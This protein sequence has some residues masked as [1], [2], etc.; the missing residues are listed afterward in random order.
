[1]AWPTVIIKIL[2]LMNGPIAGVEHHFLFVGYGQVTGT[3]R[4]LLMVD[5]TSDL[6]EAL[7]KADESLLTTVKAAQ[8]NG[9][10]EWTA[11]VMILDPADNWQDAIRKANETSS[12]EAFVLDF[13]AT[14]KKL[15]EDAIALRTELKSS[16]GREVFAVCCLPKIDNDSVNGDDWASWLASTVAIPKDVA[17]EYITVVPRVHVDGSTLGKYCGRLANQEVSLAD[18]PARVKTGS[19]LGSTE[20]LTDKNG[21]PLELAILKTLEQNRL[22]V[23]MWYPDYPGQYWTTGRTLDVPG[24][25]YQDIRHIRVAMKAARKV[26]IRAIARIADRTLNS[27]PGSMAQAKLYFTQDLRTM[28]QTGVPGEILPPEDDDIQIKWVTSEEVEIYL[29]VQP[30]DCPVKIT[31]AIAIKQGVTQ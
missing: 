10:S 31:I 4:Q 11:G 7:S 17:S 12:F 26:R 24:G 21:K 22:A 6:D 14:E 1:M 30:Y 5:A 19:V 3:E 29:A 2:N 18:S 9:K 8:L 20:L 13:P 27:T 28:A 16:L 23:P 25:D 15:L